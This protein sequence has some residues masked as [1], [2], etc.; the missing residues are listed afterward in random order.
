M[1]TKLLSAM[2]CIV[3]ICLP[4]SGCG[5]GSILGPTPTPTPIPIGVITGRIW[6]VDRAEPVHTIV[7]LYQV[8]EGDTGDDEAVEQTETDEDGY[9]SFFIA[10]PG[11][12]RIGYSNQTLSDI[13]EN[14]AIG[15][16]WRYEWLYERIVVGENGVLSDILFISTNISIEIGDEII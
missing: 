16:D 5:L 8:K 13:C 15:Q 4:M 7:I 14:L 1:N 6:L 11:T 10:E 9:Y 3:A 2:I 12:Y